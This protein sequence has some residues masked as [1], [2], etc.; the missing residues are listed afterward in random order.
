MF[1]RKK[2]ETNEWNMVNSFVYNLIQFFFAF[3]VK[4]KSAK[5]FLV[6]KKLCTVQSV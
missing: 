4:T 5:K 3:F 2:L 1:R 6:L